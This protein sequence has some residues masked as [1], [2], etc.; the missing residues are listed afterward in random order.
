M[1]DLTEINESTDRVFG[2]MGEKGAVLARLA[3]LGCP[4]PDGFVITSPPS[5]I[6]HNRLGLSDSLKKEIDEH[7][8]RLENKTGRHFF[9]ADADGVISGKPAGGGLLPPFAQRAPE[10]YQVHTPLQNVP[11]HRI[12]SNRNR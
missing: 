11:K 7:L 8:R 10:H 1:Y 3:N 5:T 4:V 12:Q 9:A 2:R 6:S